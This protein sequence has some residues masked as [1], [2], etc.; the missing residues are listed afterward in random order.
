MRFPIRFP[1]IGGLRFG[2]GKQWRGLG[3]GSIRKGAFTMRLFPLTKF[4][5]FFCQAFLAS[6]VTLLALISSSATPQ[7]VFKVAG[8]LWVNGLVEVNGRAAT[9]GMTVFSGGKIKVGPG[10][11]ATIQLGKRTGSIKL[12]AE[13]EMVLNL[14]SGV[15]G[16]QLTKGRITVVTPQGVS[17]SVPTAMGEVVSREPL[18][19]VFTIEATAERTKICVERGKGALK[20]ASPVPA[21]KPSLKAGGTLEN[22]DVGEALTATANGQLARHRCTSLQIPAKGHGGG[23]PG[24]AAVPV[25]IGAAAG[26]IPAVAVGARPPSSGVIFSPGNGE[27]DVTPVRP[28]PTA[29][30]CECRFN[31]ATGR[32]L[33]PR[34]PTV[35]CRRQNGTAVTLALTCA[36]L[37][38]YFNADG[39]PRAGHEEDTCGVCPQN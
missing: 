12:M 23:F 13:S 22:V 29:P 20:L 14:L 3:G 7:T 18:E 5:S 17:I 1:F 19:S 10:G 26:G 24:G 27:P 9:T 31:P 28:T 4:D 35:I 32:V 8:E 37:P 30:F 33:N 2:I 34:Q 25:I 39:T 36:A 38:T 16:G 11:A 15:I 21:D 6:V